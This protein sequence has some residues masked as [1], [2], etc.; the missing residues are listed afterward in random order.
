MQ[1]GERRRL[2]QPEVLEPSAR[3]LPITLVPLQSDGP[4]SLNVTE[5][6]GFK[7]ITLVEVEAIL[8]KILHEVA[9]NR[10]DDLFA[11]SS[12]EGPHHQRVPK[13]GKIT[14][15]IFRIL[16]SDGHCIPLEIRVPNTM[17]CMTAADAELVE[18]WLAHSHFTSPSQRAPPTGH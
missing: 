9:L 7:K 8:D 5:I 1:N 16:F 4:E 3:K 12:Q 18:R 11:C 13:T 17:S 15:A 2:G 14:R 10:A 6:P